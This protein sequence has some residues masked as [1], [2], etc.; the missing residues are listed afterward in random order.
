MPIHISFR[1]LSKDNFGYLVDGQGVLAQ[2]I[3]NCH[4]RP[5]EEKNL[6][7]SEECNAWCR[8]L[9]VRDNNFVQHF[10]YSS[11]KILHILFLFW[12]I[13]S[14]Y[15][16]MSHLL[17]CDECSSMESL[18]QKGQGSPWLGRWWLQVHDMCEFCSYWNPYSIEAFWRVEGVSGA[19]YCFI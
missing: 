6:C 15:A 4:H 19:L 1:V 9:I 18:G 7:T 11:F 14:K 10:I 12:Y 8:L 16:S 17:I 5:W 3:K 2:P 13:W